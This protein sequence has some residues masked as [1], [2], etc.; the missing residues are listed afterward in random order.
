MS[1]Y[2]TCKKCG[3]PLYAD[4]MAI[5]RKLILRN[6]EEFFCIDCLAD[7][8]GSTREKVEALIEHYRKSG[9]CTL[10]R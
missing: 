8:F 3:A 6:A 7:Y 4:D 2:K 5:H 9:E 1:N 10:F